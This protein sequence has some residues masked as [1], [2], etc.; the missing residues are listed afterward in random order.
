MAFAMINPHQLHDYQ[1]FCR[2]I[3]IKVEKGE[4]ISKQKF[5][6]PV[7]YSVGAIDYSTPGNDYWFDSNTILIY[8]RHHHLEE[9]PYEN[10]TIQLIR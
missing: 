1:A 6:R 2:L 7:D 5:D 4:V 3:V 8:K 9:R 10:D